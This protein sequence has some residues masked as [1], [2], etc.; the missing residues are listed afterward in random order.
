MGVKAVLLGLN[1]TGKGDFTA[2]IF[3]LNTKTDIEK[4]TIKYNGVTYLSKVNTRLN[5]I[6]N[7]DINDQKYTLKESNLIVNALEVNLNGFLQLNE[8]DIAIDFSFNT[9]KNQFKDV[10]SILPNAYTQDF[11]NVKGRWH[12]RFQ[13]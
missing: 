9:P 6:I 7:A 1:H 5:A 13:W 10:L 12:F 11:A 3:D 2:S 4:A 8:Q